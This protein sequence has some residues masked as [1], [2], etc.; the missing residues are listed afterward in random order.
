MTSFEAAVLY[1]EA[2]VLEREERYAEARDAFLVV[3]DAMEEAGDMSLARESR[4]RSLKN[5]VLL[6]ARRRWPDIGDQLFPHHVTFSR[7][8]EGG[9]HS[10]A[11]LF[12]RRYPL[13]AHV[14][15]SRR[16]DVRLMLERWN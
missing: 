12:V 6:W 11:H 13:W 14:T 4:I 16:G 9:A 8:A 2:V 7:E 1:A 10:R 15:V 3:A 5:H